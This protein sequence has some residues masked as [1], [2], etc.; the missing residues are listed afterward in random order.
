MLTCSF[1]HVDVSSPIVKRTARCRYSGR[2][3]KAA[4]LPVP[5]LLTLSQ[6]S[7]Q[8]RR[9][10]RFIGTRSRFNL[11]IWSWTGF[12]KVLQSPV[13]E[14]PHLLT[15][16]LY[17][18]KGVQSAA[19]FSVRTRDCYC[20][21]PMGCLCRACSL[22]AWVAKWKFVVMCVCACFVWAGLNDVNGFS[23]CQCPVN[24]GL[25]LKRPFF[26]CL[27]VYVCVCVCVR[28]SVCLQGEHVQEKFLKKISSVSLD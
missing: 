27:T 22:L 7:F 26:F 5:Y 11:V 14:K 13:L 3:S 17:H 1:E 20:S 24:T 4:A 28:P 19:D 15:P 10:G 8:Y 2:S 25:N 12:F 9:Y 21:G 6:C 16:V 18:W 23:C